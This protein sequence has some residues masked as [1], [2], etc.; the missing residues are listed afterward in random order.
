MGTVQPITISLTSDGFGDQAES[1]SPTFN[2]VPFWGEERQHGLIAGPLESVVEL[3]TPLRAIYGL[4][5]CEHLHA[6]VQKRQSARQIS[7]PTWEP[8]HGSV[9]HPEQHVGVDI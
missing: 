8:S 4:H 1:S 7:T 5:A 3:H 6:R 9:T 2:R